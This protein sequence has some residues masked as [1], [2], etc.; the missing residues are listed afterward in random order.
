[1]AKIDDIVTNIIPFFEKYPIKGIK[2]NNYL[3]FKEAAFMIKNKEHLNSKGMEKIIELKNI[4][5]K[6]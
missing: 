1:M 4:I 2:Y 3:Y 6:D 5:N